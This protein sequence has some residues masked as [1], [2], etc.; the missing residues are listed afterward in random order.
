[1]NGKRPL[2]PRQGR[3]RRVTVGEGGR[4]LPAD[5]RDV[6]GPPRGTQGPA[7][8]GVRDPAQHRGEA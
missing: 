2:P 3:K 6:G 5:R 8:K 4:F 1:M 7:R